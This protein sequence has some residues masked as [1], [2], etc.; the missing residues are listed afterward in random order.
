MSDKRVARLYDALSWLYPA[1]FRAEDGR[2]MRTV[3]VKRWRQQPRVGPRLLLLL[4]AVGDVLRHAPPL[5]WDVLRQD[6]SVALRT[7]RRAP[8]L[9]L[10]VMLVTALGIGATTAAFSVADHVLLKPL[11]FPESDRLVKIWQ[12]PPGGGWLEASPAHFRDWQTQ[13][14]SFESVAAF[15]DHS[16]NLRRR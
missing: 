10:T 9:S 4:E 15:N 12:L 16:A 2:E 11:P 8:S 14:S 5:H 1:S 7:I 13:T 3:F 6:L